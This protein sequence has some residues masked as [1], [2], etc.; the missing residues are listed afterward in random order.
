MTREEAIIRLEQIFDITNIPKT[1]M[2][3][4]MAID[5]M[6]EQEEQKWIP[7][8]ER[9]PDEHESVFAHFY[10][11]YKWTDGMFRCVSDEVIACVKTANGKRFIKALSTHDGKWF[12]K[13]CS[14][15][16]EVTHWR[17]FPEL[18]KEENNG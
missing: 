6:R 2:D 14:E 17:P 9:M 10:G 12:H 4:Q 18:P 7:V 8:T 1:Q 13:V 5:D 16:K 11:T 15:G 3:L